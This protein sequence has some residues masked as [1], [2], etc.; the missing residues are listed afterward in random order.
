M[1][2][3]ILSAA[4]FSLV[5][6]FVCGCVD[7]KQVEAMRDEAA[8]LR[9]QLKAEEV[10]RQQRLDAL[11][12]GDSGRADVQASLDATRAKEA[13]V[14]AGLSRVD[15]AIAEAKNPSGPLTKAAGDVAPLIPEPVRTPLILG[16]ALAASLLRSA[17]L[18]KG[19]ASVAQGLDKAMED[20]SEFKAKFKT[21][22]NTFRSI[23]TRTAQRVVDETTSDKPMLRLP[24]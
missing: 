12:P 20:D 18:K 15:E 14:S 8:Q 4:G 21:H 9:D 19:L 13:A 3:T 11:K 10:S 16:T 6:L 5:L 1:T 17:Q 24:V 22:A 23:Q 2:R 7:M